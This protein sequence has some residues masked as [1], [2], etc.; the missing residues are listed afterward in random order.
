MRKVPLSCKDVSFEF[1]PNAKMG[2][3]FR[4][5]SLWGGVGGCL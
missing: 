1:M 5:P 4:C 2:A 3:P